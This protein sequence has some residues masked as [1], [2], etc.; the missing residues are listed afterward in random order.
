MLPPG[1]CPFIVV[2][3]LFWF[4]YVIFGIKANIDLLKHHRRKEPKNTTKK[5]KKLKLS[6]PCFSSHQ[7][8]IP[9]Q[10]PTTIK[11]TKSRKPITHS[12][13]TISQEFVNT[14]LTSSFQSHCPQLSQ[15]AK[16]VSHHNHNTVGRLSLAR[17]WFYCNAKP[18]SILSH[19]VTH[20]PV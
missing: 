6:L 12:T 4:S 3:V 13:R 16:R 19:G 8:T 7:T 9:T 15:A 2:L 1:S 17:R 14:D 20:W 18:A 10:K 5:K 11:E